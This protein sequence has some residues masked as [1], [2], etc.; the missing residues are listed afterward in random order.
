MHGNER[1]SATLSHLMS[2]PFVT[3]P[4]FQPHIPK[5]TRAPSHRRTPRFRGELRT[6]ATTKPILEQEKDFASALAPTKP[7]LERGNVANQTENAETPQ[8]KLRTTKSPH[9]RNPPWRTRAPGTC[10]VRLLRE[11]RTQNE[12]MSQT[13]LRTQKRR[14]PNLER[15]PPTRAPPPGR[16]R[17]S[18]VLRALAT[19]K[20]I[21]EQE[22]DFASA[23][24]PTKPNLERRNAT[25]QT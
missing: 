6:L 23:L 3:H 21:L 12:G 5:T 2:I 10:C 9:T 17:A 20:P 22:K 7:N 1:A 8:T 24:A 18:H 19:T 11:S 4:H 16:T 14:K 15:K 13:K 25:N